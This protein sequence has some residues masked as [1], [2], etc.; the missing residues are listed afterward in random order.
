MPYSTCKEKGW[1]EEGGSGEEELWEE[2]G[3]KNAHLHLPLVARG[4]LL[5]I[6]G[7]DALHGGGQVG[8][9]A[10]GN[11]GRKGGV[12]GGHGDRV[13]QVKRAI[14]RLAAGLTRGG[15]AGSLA[16][17]RLRFR[18][19]WRLPPCGR[20]RL[21]RLCLFPRRCNRLAPQ[22]FLLR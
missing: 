17:R 18:I 21:L 8:G 10:A 11:Q 20:L 9:G 1:G 16:P 14:Q 12:A 3:R 6:E 22:P 13:G 7:P 2:R 5:C 19:A 4:K 15:L